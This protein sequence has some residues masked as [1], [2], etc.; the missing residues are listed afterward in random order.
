MQPVSFIY[1]IKWQ[2]V[3][4]SNSTAFQKPE[5]DLWSHKKWPIITIFIYIQGQILAKTYWCSLIDFRAVSLQA[6][7]KNVTQCLFVFQT[8][9]A[10]LHNLPVYFSEA[11]QRRLPLL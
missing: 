4:T 1:S 7:T 11:D 3:L 5:F 6:C 9:K 10:V 2:K 8:T